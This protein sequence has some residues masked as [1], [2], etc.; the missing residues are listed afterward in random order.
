MENLS[1]AT[2]N[3]SDCFLV[4]NASR[5]RVFLFFYL[6]IIITAI[7]SNIFS[8]VVAWNHIRQK[9]ELGVYLFNLAL[10]DLSYTVCLFAW[11][12][13]LWKGVWMHGAFLCVLSL[14]ILFTN[15]YTSEAL[16]CCI[17]VDRY[18]AV[19][20]P[21][22]YVHL[23]KVTTAAGVS[24]AIWTVVVGFN[25]ATIRLEDSYYENEQFSLCLSVFLPMSEHVARAT[26]ARFCLGF[27]IPVSLMV[28]T[29]WRICMAVESNQ[30][31]D[32]Q[33]WRHVSRLMIVIL[34]CLVICFGPV[35][36]VMLLQMLADDCK[37]ALWLLYLDKISVAVS[38]LNCIA[39]PFVYCF[40]TRTGMANIKRLLLFF[41][42]KRRSTGESE[43]Q[44]ES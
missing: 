18:L 19:V 4:D 24:V 37:S 39:D 29:S 43:E 1:Q 7:P 2:A 27:V 23:R 42:G 36:V 20:H 33:E 40:V 15:F 17:S 3:Y 41:H 30:A 8:L 25:A 35:H 10:S 44:T 11:T 28:F 9:N 12:D 26:V 13:F 22:K 16:L 14:N 38:S 34:L 32:Q 6:F 5:K 21:F 31:T